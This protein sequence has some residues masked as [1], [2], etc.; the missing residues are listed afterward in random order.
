MF[1]VSLL[2]YLFI[3]SERAAGETRLSAEYADWIVIK[4]PA[5]QSWRGKK[6]P[7][8]EAYEWYF[9]DKIEFSKPTLEVF[10]HR[11]HLFRMVFTMGHL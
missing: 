2:A 1:I 3:S 9:L 11:Y 4:D 10:V 8:R 6:L 5:L 7:M